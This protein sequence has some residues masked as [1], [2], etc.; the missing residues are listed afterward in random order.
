M[1]G[2]AYDLLKKGEITTDDSRLADIIQDGFFQ[3][4]GQM[5][6]CIRN[7]I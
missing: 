4:H 1:K 5:K 3:K 2:A 6:G 7:T